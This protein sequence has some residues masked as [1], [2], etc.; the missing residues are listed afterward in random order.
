MARFVRLSVVLAVLCG[1]F[2]TMLNVVGVR[3]ALV[4]EDSKTPKVG[5]PLPL[6]WPSPTTA[7]FW[8]ARLPSARR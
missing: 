8:S 3:V 1:T 6:W 4:A 2:A 5:G 7:R